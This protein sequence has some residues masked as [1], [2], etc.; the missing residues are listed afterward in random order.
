MQIGRAGIVCQPGNA[1][2]RT[3]FAYAAKRLGGR[4]HVG[5][6]AGEFRVDRLSTLTALRRGCAHDRVVVRRRVVAAAGEH[7]GGDRRADR[8]KC[9]ADEMFVHDESS[10]RNKALDRVY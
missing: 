7:G 5:F 9:R 8:D 1:R 6:C 3:G 4:V 10:G 2:L